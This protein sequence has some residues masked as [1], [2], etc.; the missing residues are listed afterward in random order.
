[1]QLCWNLMVTSQW[2]TRRSKTRWI[3]PI[4]FANLVTI[5]YTLI[6]SSK[7]NSQQPNPQTNI[8]IHTGLNCSNNTMSPP[9]N[10]LCF[11]TLCYGGET[12][13]ITNST[14]YCLPTCNSFPDV[15]NSNCSCGNN[16][17]HKGEICGDHCYVPPSCLPLPAESEE[18]G[19]MCDTRVERVCGPHRIC[20]KMSGWFNKVCLLLDKHQNHWSTLIVS[21]LAMH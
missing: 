7:K 19:C 10:C 20:G 4:Q 13:V 12:C 3:L 21:D 6:F 9:E 11:D 17:C 2:L 8:I 15:A 16:I 5:T 18:G 1:M 14:G